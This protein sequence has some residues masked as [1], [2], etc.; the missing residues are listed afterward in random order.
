MQDEIAEK[1]GF[2]LRSHKHELY[3][4]CPDCQRK[5]KL[6]AARGASGRGN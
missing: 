3:G 4:V 5:A 6:A 2:V 1:H